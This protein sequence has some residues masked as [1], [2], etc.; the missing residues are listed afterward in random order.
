MKTIK[1]SKNTQSVSK[2]QTKA[3]K[4]KTSGNKYH[5]TKIVTEDGTF[6]SKREYKRWLVL[7]DME[8]LGLISSLKRQ[9]SYE[10]IPTQKLDTPRY[11]KKTNKYQ[12]SEI[13][14]RYIADFVYEE[15]GKFVVE[16]TKGMQ[17]EKY[18]IKR[19]LM[20]YVHGIE[21][22]EV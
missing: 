7:K 22:R 18:I 3:K 10:L 8:R 20:K 5:A 12:R 1:Q 14:V 21:I 17:T 6:D 4:K 16:D 15:D 13:S 11:N 9:V 19:K 2:K